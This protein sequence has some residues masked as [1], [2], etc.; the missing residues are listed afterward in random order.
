MMSPI[1]LKA[2]TLILSVLAVPML[3]LGESGKAST[4]SS[5]ALNKVIVTG[6]LIFLYVIFSDLKRYTYEVLNF[7]SSKVCGEGEVEHRPMP[8]R[9]CITRNTHHHAKHPKKATR[10]SPSRI[11]ITLVQSTQ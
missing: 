4:T 1:P 6:N 11:E 10:V 2:G 3:I 7:P 8:H 9:E 5:R